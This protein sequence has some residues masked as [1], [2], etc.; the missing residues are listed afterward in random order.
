MLRLEWLK[1]G[2]NVAYV[3]AAQFMDNFEKETGLS[4]F[5]KEVEDF[6]ANPTPEGKTLIGTK[7]TAVKIFIPDVSF[8]EHIEMGENP[9]IYMGEHY[10]A[11]CIYGL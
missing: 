11:Y 8:D 6:V 3:E 2:D 9:W 1:D 5:R 10:P 4:K 7:R